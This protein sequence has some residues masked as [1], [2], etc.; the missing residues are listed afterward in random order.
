MR[1]PRI[2]AAALV[3][4]LLLPLS[5][6]TTTSAKCRNDTCTVAVK[7]NG[8]ASTEI[9]DQQVTFRDL[10]A[11]SVT[12][13]HADDTRTIDLGQTAVVGPM[14]VTVTAAEPGRAELTISAERRG[15]GSGRSRSARD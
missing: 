10:V 15:D 6:C 12:V 9:L 2:V 7:T 8:S 4:A 11:G 5:A 14:T 1:L 3:P 13:V